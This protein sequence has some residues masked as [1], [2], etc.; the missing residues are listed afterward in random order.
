MAEHKHPH[1][2]RDVVR[3][4]CFVLTISDTRHTDDDASGELIARAL[5]DLGHELSGRALVPDDAE[6]IRHTVLDVVEA[7]ATDVL[8]TTGG[9]GVAARDTTPE[10]LTPLFTCAIEGFGELFRRLSY[11]EIGPRAMLTRATAGV[12][13]R[14]LVFALPGSPAACR[15]ALDKII[16]PVLGHAVGLLRAKPAPLARAGADLRYYDHDAS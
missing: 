16:L 1:H 2:D 15:L 13:D 14:T 12:I 8:I 10:A 7:G 11:D 3:A 9:T 4:R 5:S 6:T